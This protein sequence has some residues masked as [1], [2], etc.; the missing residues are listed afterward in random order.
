MLKSRWPWFDRMLL[1]NKVTEK[2]L[3]VYELLYQRIMKEYELEWG[4]FKIY[5]GLNSGVLAAL[6]FLMRP[7]VD[8]LFCG[9]S[10]SLFLVSLLL[11][12]VGAFFSF[13]WIRLNKDIR[14]WKLLINDVIADVE[15]TLFTDEDLAL[16]IKITED[17]PR[18]SKIGFKEMMDVNIRIAQFFFALWVSLAIVLISLFF[19]SCKEVSEPFHNYHFLF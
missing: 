19:I 14:H 6:G 10:V 8:N 2:E 7:H 15:N 12:V 9:I 4:R 18:K 3:K 11:C 17:Y 5:L 1:K 16:Y 13:A